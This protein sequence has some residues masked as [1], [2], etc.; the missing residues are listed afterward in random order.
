MEVAG[1]PRLFDAGNAF[2]EGGVATSSC[3]APEL[4]ARLATLG[5]VAGCP[6]PELVAGL[7]TLALLVADGCPAP[8]LVAGLAMPL[9]AGCPAPEL[10]AGLA[11]LALILTGC[12]APVLVGGPAPGAAAHGAEAAA[13]VLDDELLAALPLP[14]CGAGAG[15]IFGAGSTGLGPTLPFP[16]VSAIP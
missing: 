13:A 14:P 9:G 12:P 2:K 11:T 10:A 7:A 16:S 3:P 5:L 8:E 15:Q 6:A 4:V 1:S